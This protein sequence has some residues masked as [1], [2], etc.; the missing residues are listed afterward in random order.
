MA[1]TVIPTIEVNKVEFKE[2]VV[3]LLEDFVHGDASPFKDVKPVLEDYLD[4]ATELDATQKV[5]RGTHTNPSYS[6]VPSLSRYS[7]PVS[8]NVTAVVAKV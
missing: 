8:N 7:Y 5:S 6:K 3:D 2:L 4:G 1:L